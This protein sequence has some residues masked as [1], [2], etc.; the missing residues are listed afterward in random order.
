MRVLD[1][2][3]LATIGGGV[4]LVLGVLLTLVALFTYIAQ[5]QDVGTGNYGS[6]QALRFVALSLPAQGFEFMP[7]AALIGTL[8]GMGLLARNSELT[9]MRAAGVS[10]G[11]IGASMV[12]AGLLLMGAALVLGEFIAP[13]AS[14][15]ARTG[16]AMDRYA[17]ISFAG[18]GGAW[19]RD[20]NLILKAEQR[21]REGILRG[22][23]VFEMTPENRVSAVGRAVSARELPQGGWELTDYVASQFGPEGV[24]TVDESR[25]GLRTGL[26][27]AFLAM[28]AAD[29]MELSLRELRGAIGYLRDNGQQSRAQEFAFWSIVA[30]IAAIPLAVLLALPFLFG[31]LRSTGSGARATLGLV[32]GLAYFILQRM[33]QSGTI[34]FGL[35]PVLLAWL[36]TAILAAAVAILIWRMPA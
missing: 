35:D 7:M 28:A 16:K 36:P 33:V 8:L 15:S 2:Y 10:I 11:R 30:R 18:R 14:D 5:Q 6:L 4:A 22:I 1:R 20:G 17:S 19:V 31:S 34:A 23:T 27:S 29:P 32:L 25:R 26:S 24:A 9:V 3:I 21:S 12:L 13:E